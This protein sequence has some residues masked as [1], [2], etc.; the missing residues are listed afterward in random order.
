MPSKPDAKAL[1]GTS[2]KTDR[3]AFANDQQQDHDKMMQRMV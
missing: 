1:V 2:K 3:K